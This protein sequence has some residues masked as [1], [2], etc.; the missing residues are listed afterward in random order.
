[1]RLSEVEIEGE[2]FSRSDL[3]LKGALAAA[4][5]Y[6]LGAVG[7]YVRD[8]IGARARSDVQIL[9]FLLPFEY[10]QVSLYNR[11]SSGRNS[12]DQEMPLDGSQKELLETLVVEDGKHVEALKDEI[13]TLGGKPVGKGSYAFAFLDFDTAL[14]IETVAVGVYNGAIPSLESEKVRD[15]VSSIVQ[16][17]GRHAASVLIP[18]K[19]EPA[20]E[21]FDLGLEENSAIT[22]VQQFTGVFPDY[23]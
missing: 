9:N 6:G 15:L 20:P 22:L 4:A 19:E 2:S 5:L 7:P 10:L 14:Q 16:V 3:L 18:I 12:K 13:A 21:A 1:V 23:E 17:D 8:A 11:A